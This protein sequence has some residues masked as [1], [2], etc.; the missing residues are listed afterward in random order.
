MKLQ[1]KLVIGLFIA[2]VLLIPERLFV[3][4]FQTNTHTE[5]QE[6]IDRSMEE[7]QIA[8]EIAIIDAELSHWHEHLNNPIFI[9]VKLDTL[10]SRVAQ[11]AQLQQSAAKQKTIG[12]LGKLASQYR[13]TFRD[14][15]SN[16]QLLGLQAHIGLRGEV[17]EIT[18]AFE[19]AISN[20]DTAT[21]QAIFSHMRVSEKN[22]VL[23]PFDFYLDDIKRRHALFQEQLLR[24]RLSQSM[25]Q[26]LQ[27]S[28]SQYVQAVQQYAEATQRGKVTLESADFKDMDRKS[29]VVAR[30][31]HRNHVPNLWQ[32]FLRLN[33]LITAFFTT[34]QELVNARFKEL[35]DEISQDLKLSGIDAGRK[36]QII[37]L[38]ER[39]RKSLSRAAQLH[40][41]IADQNTELGLLTEKAQILL[42]NLLLATQRELA[43]QR[44]QTFSHLETMMLYELLVSL[45]IIL[46][47]IGLANWF[48]RTQMVS[49]L[50]KLERHAKAIG[51]GQFDVAIEHSGRDEIGTLA[52]QFES[53]AGELQQF[54]DTQKA[55]REKSVNMLRAE[56][57][58]HQAKSQF[59]ANVSH[60]IRTPLNAIIGFTHLIKRTDLNSKQADYT[61]KIHA[62]ANLLLTVINDILDYSKLEAGKL[63][64]EETPFALDEIL[65][66]LATL[67]SGSAQEKG[68]ELIFWREPDVPNHV[69]GDSLRLTQVL[70]NLCS[71][72]L[73]F[74]QS[75]RIV[76][77]ITRVEDFA[78]INAWPFKH[79]QTAE[80]EV[81]LVAIQFSVIDTGIGIAK[82]KQDKLFHSFTQA[83][84]STTREFG[85]T[86]L[87][88]SIC[89]EIVKAMGGH[90]S[91]SS[92]IGKGSRF[93]FTLPLQTYVEDTQ[94]LR[95]RLSKVRELDVVLVEPDKVLQAA[96]LD[97]L[98]TLQCQHRVFSDLRATTA[99]LKKTEQ[100]VIVMLDASLLDRGDQDA[101][102]RFRQMCHE[103]DNIK[104]IMLVYGNCEV[105]D[106]PSPET[107]LLQKPLN[108][109]DLYDALVEVAV[110]DDAGE[111]LPSPQQPAFLSGYRVLLV[112]DNDINQQVARELLESLGAK[113]TIA[114]NGQIALDLLDSQHFEIIFMDIQ[115]PVM[116]GYE[117]SKAIR[118]NDDWRNIP[119]IA[120]TANAMPHEIRHCQECGM[121]DHLAKPVDPEK[122]QQ[123]LQRWL[124]EQQTDNTGDK[125]GASAH[126][127]F[128]ALNA[129]Q[130]LTP[131]YG[132]DLELALHTMNNNTAL[133]TKLLGQFVDK[134][135][136]AGDTLKTL[137]T[138][139][140]WAQLQRHAHN[141]KGVS[142]NL[143][144]TQLGELTSELEA[145]CRA[146]QTDDQPNN[147][148]K[149]ET[150][151]ACWRQFNDEFQ[152][153]VQ[154][155]EQQQALQHITRKAGVTVGHT[156][157][158]D[159]ELI[160]TL[161]QLKELVQAG[162]YQ[163]LE[164]CSELK[165]LLVI[166]N[167]ES[168]WGDAIVAMEQSLERYDFESALG[169]LEGMLAQLSA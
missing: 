87:G 168:R 46:T 34:R 89:K 3:Y 111:F 83:D 19:D 36:S 80:D 113:V 124:S 123:K 163:S 6:A 79:A 120:M 107:R 10:Q 25:K 63:E 75:G 131:I 100:N 156:T 73:K 52:R 45:L 27:I 140:D 95:S 72:A 130:P 94:L 74:T 104:V 65:N 155:I 137:I 62:S 114:S 143:G 71:N 55:L 93:D 135:R 99:H 149:S 134:Y 20:L 86:G 166:E 161:Q 54:H 33:D 22:Y 28:I 162:N 158:S 167:E 88:L 42:S 92:D 118:R 119:I 67:I 69:M 17:R 1:T 16:W 121:N 142:K 112:E 98:D 82:E 109:S 37:R 136:N 165:T 164:L 41:A 44:S 160:S 12:Q 59:L 43:K 141:L 90:I 5:L 153:I 117:C 14:L 11:L 152:Q 115:M 129:S 31:L 8:Q 144:M 64:L 78:V 97:M 29:R 38:I 138:M 23:K 157:L 108:T 70:T 102:Q 4:H 125:A 24:S 126:D 40:A 53:M 57:G 145:A 96:I 47:L 50:R 61:N 60:E 146:L 106:L 116:D 154:A 15:V 30:L 169:I 18:L 91:V 128:E 84:A 32:N 147:Q 58:A 77:R 51:K 68:L 85:G 39:Y 139:Q 148:S 48:V 56:Q 101:W 81:D 127:D 21:L 2:C 9:E 151:M 26:D 110:G 7:Q 76:V 66:S 132:I 49:P 103:Q 122:L 35:F 105:Q 13:A 133:L 150:V 159:K